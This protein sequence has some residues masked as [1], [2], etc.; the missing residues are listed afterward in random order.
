[1]YYKLLYKY[2]NKSIYEYSIMEFH[3]FLNNKFWATQELVKNTE[4]Y[5]FK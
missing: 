4:G 2:K 5:G 1:M 3:V